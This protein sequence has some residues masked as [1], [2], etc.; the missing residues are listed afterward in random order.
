MTTSADARRHDG[1]GRSVTG[2]VMYSLLALL[3]IPAAAQAQEKGPAT[4]ELRA[5]YEADQGDRQFTR[6]PTPEDWEAISARDAER[7]ARVYELLKADRLV[8]AEDFYHAAMVL[9]HGDSQRD[10]LVSHILSMAAA[11]KGDERGRWL[12]AASLDRYLHRTRMPQRFGTQYV[13]V[14]LED[15]FEPDP[16]QP[17][18]QGAYVRWLPDSVREIFGVDPLAEQAERLRT[19]TA[20]E[21]RVDIQQRDR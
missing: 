21:G 16:S 15:P 8:V 4:D 6:D 11:F 17:R 10:I 12:S 18:S 1:P 7:Q 20:R 3:L 2:L 13:K 9:Q 14:S 5:L 19:M